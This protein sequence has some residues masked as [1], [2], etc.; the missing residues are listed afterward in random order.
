MTNNP[1]KDKILIRRDHILSA[2]PLFPKQGPHK[3]GRQN[4]KA[5][6]FIQDII[7]RLNQNPEKVEDARKP[8]WQLQ[9][10]S[11]DEH[12]FTDAYKFTQPDPIFHENP[13]DTK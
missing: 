13:A 5:F 7:Q 10:Y 11:K 2:N 4:E 6:T 1:N 3:F 8:L 9:K 12:Q